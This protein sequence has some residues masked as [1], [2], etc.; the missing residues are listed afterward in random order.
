MILALAYGALHA[1]GLEVWLLNWRGP[2]FFFPLAFEP[3]PDFHGENPVTCHLT[4]AVE[5]RHLFALGDMNCDNHT[6]RI[7]AL[8]SY[9]L[10]LYVILCMTLCIT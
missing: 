2:N 9:C 5:I 6:V 1:W 4:F 3:V 8:K 10:M 7:S